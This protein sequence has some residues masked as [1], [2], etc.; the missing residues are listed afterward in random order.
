MR[1]NLTGNVTIR[2]VTYDNAT[3]AARAL[4]VSKQTI[5]SARMG[6]KLDYVGLGPRNGGRNTRLCRIRG[7]NYSS[8][9]DAAKALG[10]PL[11]YVSN[12]LN[13]AESLGIDVS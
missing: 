4:G 12:F 5:V 3:S 11:S 2:G 9:Q 10:V 1:K 13:L 8:R 6:G 7:V